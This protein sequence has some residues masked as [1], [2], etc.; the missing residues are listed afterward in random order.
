MEVAVPA[1]ALKRKELYVNEVSVDKLV[2]SEDLQTPV[3]SKF[4]SPGGRF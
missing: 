3:G 4:E 1:L 2:A